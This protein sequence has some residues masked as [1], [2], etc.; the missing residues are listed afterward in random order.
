MAALERQGIV[1]PEGQHRRKEYGEKYCMYCGSASVGNQL[2]DVIANQLTRDG[3][4]VIEM[5]DR[6]ELERVVQTK[7]AEEHSILT[8]QLKARIIFLIRQTVNLWGMQFKTAWALNT[9][10]EC[11]V[12]L[13][14]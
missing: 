10:H 9:A 14:I 12:S 13:Q 6:L 11:L 2:K 3:F 8:D 1:S 7:C 5:T 4:Y